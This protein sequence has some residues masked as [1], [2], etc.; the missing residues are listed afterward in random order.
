MQVPAAAMINMLGER[1]GNGIPDNILDVLKIDDVVLHLY[2]KKE[3][4]MG[5]KM[6]HLT[7]TANTVDEAFARASK[8]LDRLV[9]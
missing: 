4:R 2:G 8:A 7:V 5:R 1:N 6:G 9:W 3:V